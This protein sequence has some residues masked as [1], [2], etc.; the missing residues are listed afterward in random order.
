MR[1]VHRPTR[2]IAEALQ[3]IVLV[4]RS[5]AVHSLPAHAP[6]ACHLTHRP[7]VG[8]DRQNCFVPLLS[9]AQLPVGFR[10]YIRQQ[11][12]FRNSHSTAR[13]ASRVF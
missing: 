10:K 13:L 12:A 9:H 11:L 1:A 3:S 7:T 5:P 6:L 4:A 2:P 8:N